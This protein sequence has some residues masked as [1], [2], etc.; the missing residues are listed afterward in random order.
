MHFVLELIQNADDNSYETKSA[1]KEDVEPTLVFLIEPNNITLFNNE[2]GFKSTHI[3]A[4]CDVKASTKGKHQK[5]YIGRK[6]IGFKSVFTMTDRP[7]IHSNGYH[8]KFDARSGHIG[9]ILPYWLEDF[10]TLNK[11]DAMKSYVKSKIGTQLVEKIGELN[12]CI[13]LPL[14][15]ESEMQRH[16]SS[17]LTNNFNDIKPYLLLFLN[18]LRN[19]VIINKNDTHN[20]ELIYH[21][22]DLGDNLIEINTQDQ[23]QKWLVVRESLIVPENLKPNSNVES[24]DLCFAFP[25]DNLKTA[26]SFLPKMDVF[27]YLPLRSFGFSFIIQADFVV[28]ASRQDITQ[29]NDWNQWIAKQIPSLFI[30]SLEHFKQAHIVFLINKSALYFGEFFV[31]WRNILNGVYATGI[32]RVRKSSLFQS[33]NIKVPIMHEIVNKIR[34]RKNLPQLFYKMTMQF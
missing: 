31:Q 3:N 7:E 33:K 1:E 27:A 30:K 6:G 14:K 18:R 13:Q 8:I 11:I 20:N 22:E 16:K 29:D 28:P 9:Y 21:R 26:K 19:L 23:T 25:L 2:I 24:T 32:F 15:S 4:I 17:L 34:V 5:G 10:L 12:T